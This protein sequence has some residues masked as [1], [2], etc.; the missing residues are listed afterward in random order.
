MISQKLY[1]HFQILEMLSFTEWQKSDKKK[2][3]KIT[4]KLGK[5]EGQKIIDEI[6]KESK[7]LRF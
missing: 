2:Q 3:I 5:Y 4:K 7:Q 6:E 1:N